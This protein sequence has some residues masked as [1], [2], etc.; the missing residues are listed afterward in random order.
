MTD[1]TLEQG[2]ERL[3]KEVEDIELRLR[4]SKFQEDS[5]LEEHSSYGR[6]TNLG[7]AERAEASEA[8]LL[9]TLAWVINDVQ[10]W[11]DAVDREFS[12]DGW[13][14]EHF[15]NFHWRGGLDKARA[16]IQSAELRKK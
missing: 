3:R 16:V 14:D 10:N 11:C 7:R 8:K 6:C 13:D 15:K 1:E 4:T 12:W 9:D 5:Y 2:N